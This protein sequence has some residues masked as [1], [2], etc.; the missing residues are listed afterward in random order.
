VGRLGEIVLYRC[1]VLTILGHINPDRSVR[2]SCS[3]LIVEI[4]RH[5]FTAFVVKT[6]SAITIQILEPSFELDE[7]DVSVI[8]EHIDPHPEMKDVA[9]SS[10]KKRYV[11]FISGG[12]CRIWS[13]GWIFMD[14][15]FAECDPDLAICMI[16]NSL[17][18]F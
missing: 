11:I 13:G 5:H 14:T 7:F 16:T 1:A 3:D 4:I 15:F 18:L 12:Q 8:M 9:M 6:Q 2:I 17:A 10:S